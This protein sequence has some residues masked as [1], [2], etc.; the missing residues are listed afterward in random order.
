MKRFFPKILARK[1]LLFSLLA[2]LFILL[3]L[4]FLFPQRKQ[5]AS[6]PN[7]LKGSSKVALPTVQKESTKTYT[8]KYFSISYPDNWTIKTDVIWP[9]GQK[10]EIQPL[11]T[12]NFEYYPMFTLEVYQSSKSG[13]LDVE[14]D[15][16]VRMH[17]K[18]AFVDIRGVRGEKFF[19]ALPFKITNT[20]PA[21][22]PTQDT[23]IFMSY[24]NYRYRLAYQYE[25]KAKNRQYEE[26]F[27][28]MLGAYKFLTP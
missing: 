24:G 21:L 4:P 23:E 25:G 13:A 2:F 16:L 1:K 7:S 15:I 6:L 27:Q 26:L 12:P 5:Q 18:H 20:K 22:I 19:R 14:K 17:Y 9:I 11:N 8:G 10:M 3:L 28:N